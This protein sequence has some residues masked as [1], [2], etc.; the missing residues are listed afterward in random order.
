MPKILQVGYEDSVRSKLG[1][2][3]SELANDIIN[4]PLIVDLAESVIVKKVPDYAT[5]TD[6]ADLLFLQNSVVSYICYLLAPTMAQR[7][8]QEV[9]TLDV[10]WKKGKVD[11]EARAQDFLAESE[12][13]LNNITSIEIYS[14]KSVL[15]GIIKAGGNS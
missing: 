3:A 8:K 11:W 10:K 14:G 4:Q 7:V 15:F 6:E 9:S 12:L 5:I 2:K 13:S 1:V